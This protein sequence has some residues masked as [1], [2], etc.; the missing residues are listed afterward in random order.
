MESA[1]IV[2]PAVTEVVQRQVC[3]IIFYIHVYMRACTD[4]DSIQN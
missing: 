3:D 4:L 1:I 2:V